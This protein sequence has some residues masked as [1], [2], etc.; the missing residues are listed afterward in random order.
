MSSKGGLTCNDSTRRRDV[1]DDALG[2]SL[3]Q[4][5]RYTGDAKLL[6]PRPRL[7]SKQ[8]KRRRACTRGVYVCV[9]VCVCVYVHPPFLHSPPHTHTVSLSRR[10]FD[11][12]VQLLCRVQSGL[13]THPLKEPCDVIRVIAVQ[14]F[15]VL[16]WPKHQLNAK[17][18]MKTKQEN[19]Q[20]WSRTTKIH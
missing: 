15:I 10:Q 5:I 16:F 19:A 20:C 2:H 9:C 17:E 12:P 11:E 6:R 3:R 7:P 13:H 14:L 8:A 1:W 4:A 18:P